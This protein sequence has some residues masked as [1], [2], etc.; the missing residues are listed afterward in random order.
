MNTASL[1]LPWFDA[2]DHVAT[3]SPFGVWRTSQFWLTLP[4]I[5][6]E[7]VIFSFPWFVGL[8]A[9]LLGVFKIF[10]NQIRQCLRLVLP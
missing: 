7:I 1:P 6:I 4:A 5:T 3:A 10:Q 9:A 2:I 8:G